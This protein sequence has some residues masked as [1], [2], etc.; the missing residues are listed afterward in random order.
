MSP[1]PNEGT[2]TTALSC[3]EA[4]VLV[5]EFAT[6]KLQAQRMRILRSHLTSCSSCRESYRQAVETTASLSRFTVEQREKIR[7]ERQRRSLHTKVFGERKPQKRY[8]PFRLRLVLMPAL[9]IYL[10]T[11]ITSL[12]PPPARIEL[13]SSEGS[14]LISGNP[15]DSET[16]NLLVLPG[17]WVT[18]RSLSKAKLDGQTAM[19]NVGEETDLLI[20]DAR[21]V[22]LRLRRGYLRLD[23]SATVITVLGLFEIEAGKGVLHVSSAG[24]RVEPQSGEWKFFDKDGER[25]L[26]PG[27]TLMMR[28]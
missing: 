14:V 13:I 8:L 11:Q 1:T 21:P 27:E 7:I 26:T 5:R 4:E 19:F 15:V 25:L 3:E 9:F 22:R 12:G 24:L 18:T 20:E 2:A 23:G 10:V 17:R 6:G 16:E 28:P